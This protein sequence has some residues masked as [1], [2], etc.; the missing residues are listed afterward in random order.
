M[1]VSSPLSQLGQRILKRL[2]LALCVAV[3]LMVV[4]VWIAKE[5]VEGRTTT[6]DR[7]ISLGLAEHHSAWWD[8]WMRAATTMGEIWMILVLVCGVAVWAFARK[9]AKLAVVLL[10]VNA[11]SAGLNVALKHS[12][13][14]ARPTLLDKFIAP[15][16]YSFPSGHAMGSMVAYGMIAWVIGRM[17]PKLRAPAYIVAAFLITNIG[18]S[19]V[20]LGVHWFTDILAGFAAGGIMLAVVGVFAR[21]TPEVKIAD[22]EV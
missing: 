13:R 21:R 16:S 5:M 17:H 4:F 10:V 15:D 3:G 11:C 12:F 22:A 14:R 9:Y 8:A 7:A 6:F 20:Y 2:T 19:R 1:T 18:L